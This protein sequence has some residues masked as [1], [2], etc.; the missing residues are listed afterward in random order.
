M[1]S[2]GVSSR[3]GGRELPGLLG[4]WG[5]RLVT[6]TPLLVLSAGCGG[7]EETPENEAPASPTC[8]ASSFGVSTSAR[9]KAFSAAAKRFPLSSA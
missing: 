1:S 3:G 2:H 6:L 9:A 7:A 5:L 8:A 4:L